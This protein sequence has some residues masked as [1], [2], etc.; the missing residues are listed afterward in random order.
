MITIPRAIREGSVVTAGVAK[1]M[2]SEKKMDGGKMGKMC[3]KEEKW[4]KIKEQRRK[5]GNISVL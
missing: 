3:S 2:N 4:T 5:S 1:K